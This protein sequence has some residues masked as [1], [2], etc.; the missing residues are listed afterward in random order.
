MMRLWK[1]LT[2][3]VCASALVC[4]PASAPAYALEPPSD[5]VDVSSFVPHGGVAPMVVMEQRSRCAQAGVIPGSDLSHNAPA[6]VLLNID[7]LHTIATG[8]GV[9]VGIID[10]GVKPSKRLPKVVGLGDQIVHGDGLSD[11]DN[12][13]T[14]I[15]G[16]IAAQPSE[17]DGV[18]GIAPDVTLYSIRHTSEAFSPKNSEDDPKPLKTMAEDI[19]AMT[20]KG[21]DV[22]NISV[23]ACVP[24]SEATDVKYLHA[25]LNYAKKHN[26]LIV[27][28][29][30]N[31]NQSCRQNP[32]SVGR[33]WDTAETVSYPAYYAPL[34]SIIAVGGTNM[35][36]A[37]YSSNFNAPYVT[38]A[39]PAAGIVSIDRLGKI[40]NGVPSQDKGLEP[41][42]GTSFSSA[43]VTATAALLK[44]QHPDW[45]SVDIQRQIIYSATPVAGGD[46]MNWA[47][48]GILNPERALTT[49]YDLSENPWKQ[50]AP[51][52]VTIKPTVSNALAEAAILAGALAL[53]AIGSVIAYNISKR[54]HAKDHK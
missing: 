49:S 40:V 22:V 37:P 45:G 27:T 41:I 34:E 25:A 44:E 43:Y 28:S 36:G 4:A 53:V 46:G 30:G 31:V 14:I 11:C 17:K 19:V 24:A 50:D 29:V 54:N 38:V 35:M 15:A 16:I 33:G 8:K 20:N 3:G 51:K 9:K 13:G 5:D 26:T 48:F 12:H 23:T 47:G 42:A 6:S 1:R 32:P 39:A 7:K 10:S 2:V 52:P 21:M 18:V